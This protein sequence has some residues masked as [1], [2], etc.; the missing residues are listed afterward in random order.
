MIRRA[1][2][3]ASIEAAGDAGEPPPQPPALWK[4]YLPLAALLASPPP[5]LQFVLPGLLGGT[6]GLLVSAGGLGKSMLALEIAASIAVGR[7]VFGVLGEAPA[8]GR[9]IIVAA[10]DPPDILAHRLH[11][12]AKSLTRNEQTAFVENVRIKS[13]LG[14]GWNLG[15]WGGQAFAPSCGLSVLA[16]E[17][18]EWQPTLVA[19]DTFNRCLAGMSE[20]DNA[21]V[22]AVISEIEQVI[23]PT[24]TA[25]LVL[26]HVAKGAALSG[27]GDA[28]QASRG[29][30]ALTDNA[31]LQVNLVGMSV[32][33]A[34]ARGIPANERRQWVRLVWA[35]SNYAAPRPDL[36]LRRLPGGLLGSDDPPIPVTTATTERKGGARRRTGGDAV[37]ARIPW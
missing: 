6:L 5:L 35:K 4:D 30:S 22:G 32:D 36:W 31:R 28:Q 37:D 24:K 13:V 9:V 33:E 23:A 29:A 21:V 12:L 2:M 3:I 10:E 14:Q 20:N 27:Q 11:A 1:S 17:I 7:D 34:D 19:I 26:H 16:D 25:A 18:K 8:P 15:T